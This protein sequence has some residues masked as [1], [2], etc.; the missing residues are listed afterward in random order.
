VP[1][2]KLTRKEAKERTRQRL[3]DAVLDHV[4]QHGL[5]GLTT[6]KVAD[7]AGIAQS[8]FYV[9]FT[10]MDEALRAAADKAGAEIRTLIRDARH[11]MDFSDPDRAYVS[12][13]EG[14]IAALLGEQEF[15]ELL[16]SHRRDK[17]SPLAETL[18][19]VLDD[20]RADLAGDLTGAGW[21]EWFE[22]DVDLYAELMVG[23][24]LTVVEALLDGRIKDRDR[25]L[26]ALARMTRALLS[27][28]RDH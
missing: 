6:G 13:Y 25:A 16:L 15:T 4:R 8:S 18:R 3:I 23:M 22:K 28:A 10:D 27:T 1:S 12:A 17:S 26:R 20:A 2:E 5:K 21:A 7:Q 11:A 14:S 9:H 19:H 24:T